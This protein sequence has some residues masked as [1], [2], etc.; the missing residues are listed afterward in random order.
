MRKMLL[1][2][3]AMV[4]ALE[5]FLL[6]ADAR[7]LVSERRVLPGESVVVD[8]HGDLSEN[9]QASLVC[10]YFD[11][12]ALRHTVYWYSPSSMLGRDACPFLAFPPS[13]S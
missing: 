9:S 6:L 4:V 8:G 13:Q 11:G 7:I 1:G 3:A 10:T 5:L 2:V 12:R